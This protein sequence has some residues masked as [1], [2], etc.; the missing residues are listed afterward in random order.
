MIQRLNR[1]RLRFRLPRR[2]RLGRIEAGRRLYEAVEAAPSLPGP[3]EAVGVERD[4]DD[5]W[6]KPCNLRWSEAVA[7][8]SPR[9]VALDENIGLPDE[10]AQRLPRRGFA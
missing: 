6:P 4:I 10:R 1:Q 3:A 5:P 9:A 8:N 2:V 7:C